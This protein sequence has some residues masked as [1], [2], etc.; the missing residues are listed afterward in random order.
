MR[1]YV[2]VRSS[3]KH[4]LVRNAS[5]RGPMCFRLLLFDNNVTLKDIFNHVSPNKII[6]FIKRAGL[7]NTFI[8]LF[9]QY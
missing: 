9:L 4:I 7:Y 8:V 5:P 6:L 2:L 1:Y 3:F